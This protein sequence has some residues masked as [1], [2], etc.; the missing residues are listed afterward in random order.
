MNISNGQFR[1]TFCYVDDAVNMILSLMYSKKANKKIFNIG[2]Q[3]PE[4]K[5]IEIAKLVAK[6]HGKKILFR[7]ILSKY[8]SPKRRVPSTQKMYR[9]IKKKK[10]LN[11]IEGLNKT[12]LWYK[13]NY[14][15][16]FP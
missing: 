5:I 6:L 1:R 15:K 13:K 9:F 7:S 10:T 3:S 14:S 12:F 4:I 8:E 11:F 16:L 2:N